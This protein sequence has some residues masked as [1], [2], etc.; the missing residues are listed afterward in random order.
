MK[1][2]HNANIVAS[3]DRKTW[4]ALKANAIESGQ[5]HSNFH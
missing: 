2:R 1:L 4:L 3:V 5:S